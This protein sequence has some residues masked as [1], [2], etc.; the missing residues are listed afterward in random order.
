MDG[1]KEQTGRNSNFHKLLKIMTLHLGSVNMKVQTTIQRL[2][3]LGRSS[4]Y[5][6]AVCLG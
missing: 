5:G 1:S 2:D 4:I 3:V 6:I